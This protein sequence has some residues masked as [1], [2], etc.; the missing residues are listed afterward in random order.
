M[1]NGL[2][3]LKNKMKTF[4]IERLKCVLF[5]YHSRIYSKYLST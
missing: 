2:K 1:H 3:V 5:I 4:I